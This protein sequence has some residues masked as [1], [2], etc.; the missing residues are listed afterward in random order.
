MFHDN[1]CIMSKVSR[2][3]SRYSIASLLKSIRSLSIVYNHY[4][5]TE[6]DKNISLSTNPKLLPYG[7]A[8]LIQKMLF[9]NFYSLQKTFYLSIHDTLIYLNCS[10]NP[11]IET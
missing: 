2:S 6:S 4:E 8:F 11:H 9:Q 1:R 5:V 3:H 10:I 7:T